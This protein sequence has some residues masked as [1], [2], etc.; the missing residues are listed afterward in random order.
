MK[1]LRRTAARLHVPSAI[2]LVLTSPTLHAQEW[3]RA[4]SPFTL[5]EAYPE[6]A[7]TCETVKYWIDHAPDTEDRVSFAIRGE[8]VAAEWD[9][10]LAY[11]II[12]DEADVQV[13][14]VTYSKDDRDV[15]DTVLFGGG[16]SRVGERQI[17]LDP[18][19]ASLED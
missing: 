7:A 18:C 11:L 3:Q 14:C 2:W 10:A 8:L 5:G 17:M 16:Y 1:S 19:L 6:V 13:L 12:C 4:D 15:G 9:G